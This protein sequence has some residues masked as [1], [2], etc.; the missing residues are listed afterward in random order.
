[1]PSPPAAKGEEG[2]PVVASGGWGGKMPDSPSLRVGDAAAGE[3][4]NCLAADDDADADVAPA[5][6]TCAG[7]VP[8][9]L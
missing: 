2:L 1:M 7:S 3:K 5:G 8:A 9:W 4:D 6:G